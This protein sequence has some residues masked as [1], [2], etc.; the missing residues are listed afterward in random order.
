[1]VL[2]FHLPKIKLNWFCKQYWAHHYLSA[3]CKHSWSAENESK[4]IIDVFHQNAFKRSLLEAILKEYGP[5]WNRTSVQEMMFL[6]SC[7]SKNIR[8]KGF[9]SVKVFAVNL[10]PSRLSIGETS[11]LLPLSAKI[12]IPIP[13]S[14]S[15]STTNHSIQTSIFRSAHG[16]T[17]SKFSGRKSK[18]IIGRCLAYLLQILLEFCTPR[19]DPG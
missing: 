6:Q 15:Y 1:M 2:P 13:L 10:S 16:V 9:V 18:R 8:L 4:C 5:V 7:D 14:N 3:C 19:L 11:A 12:P 17:Q